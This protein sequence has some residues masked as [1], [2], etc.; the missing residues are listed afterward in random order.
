MPQPHPLKCFGAVAVALLAAVGQLFGQAVE[1][2]VDPSVLPPFLSG[3]EVYRAVRQPDGKYVVVGDFTQINGIARSCIA[4]LNVDGSLDASF[5]PGLGVDGPPSRIFRQSDGKFIIAGGFFAYNGVTCYG[6]ARVNLDGSLDPSFAPYSRFVTS[7][8]ALTLIYSAALGSDGAVTVVGSFG[9]GLQ[10]GGTLYHI[11]RFLPNGDLDPTFLLGSASFLGSTDSAYVS[12]VSVGP[13]MSILITGFFSSLG[14]TQ[15]P[16]GSAHVFAN[17]T[18]DSAFQVGA[19]GFGGLAYSEP[20]ID[21]A[22]R[23]YFNGS[24]DG[25]NGVPRPGIVRLLADGTVDPAFDAGLPDGTA[26]FGVYPSSGGGYL[27]CGNF[28]TVQGTSKIGVAKISVDGVLDGSVSF[29]IG[30]ASRADVALDDGAGNVFVG[31]RFARAGGAARSGVA[32]FTAGGVLQTSFAPTPGLFRG[33]GIVYTIAV[34]PADGKILAGGYFEFAG[35]SIPIGGLARLN[36]DGTLDSSFNVAGAG[37]NF[38]VRSIVVLANSKILVGGLFRSF[39]GVL[40]NRIVRLNANGSVDPTFDPGSGFDDA[41]YA[42]AVLSDDSIVVT[43]NFRNYNGVPRAGVA[44]LS[45]NGTLD[46]AFDPGL[47]LTDFSTAASSTSQ[48]NALLIQQPGDKIIVAGAFISFNNFPVGNIVRMNSSGSVDT[49]FTTSPGANRSIITLAA[50]PDGK[51]LAGGSFTSYNGATRR[52]YARITANG[53]LDGTFSTPTNNQ[54]TIRAIAVHPSGRIY[55]GGLSLNTGTAFRSVMRVESTGALD[56]TFDC[57][58]G[59]TTYR[60]GLTTPTN[61]AT[62][63]SLGIGTNGGGLLVG[64]TFHAFGGV[65]RGAVADLLSYPYLSWQAQNFSHAELTDPAI[66]GDNADPDG[67]GISNLAE[68]AFNLNPR[69]NSRVGLPAVALVNANGLL[70]NEI[71]FTRLKTPRG[72]DYIVET[73][74]DLQTWSASGATQILVVD[75]GATDLVTFRDNTATDPANPKRFI[76]V[77][78]TRN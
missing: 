49:T 67:D 47:G 76:R 77:R 26:V 53:G 11:A 73:S 32:R 65:A 22:G 27:L 3:G 59:A 20:Y 10:G 2:A 69:A 7:T 40:R 4:R 51:I 9:Y 30:E 36:P 45:A 75:Q 16:S 24:F 34:Q 72:A 62:V 21:A 35:E 19:A 64:G 78:V 18:V 25:F 57:G 31:G 33:L 44:K 42:I 63:Y 55:L 70:A 12:G 1:G 13:D 38:T 6:I 54:G 50:Q 71:T 5:D 37:A 28:L 56:P 15:T 68:Y 23:Y 61:N 29:D 8:A 60:Y 17:G 43:G 48:G 66:S 41:V 39:N 46:L 58:T 52:R 14:A 74:A